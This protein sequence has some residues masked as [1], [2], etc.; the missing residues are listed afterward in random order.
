[1]FLPHR[2]VCCGSPRQN[3]Y[4]CLMFYQIHLWYGT[5]LNQNESNLQEEDNL[6]E[7]YL[8]SDVQEPDGEGISL[9]TH[10]VSFGINHP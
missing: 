10:K 7:L 4:H 1:M 5:Q 9:D 2:L 3:G 8:E 6:A